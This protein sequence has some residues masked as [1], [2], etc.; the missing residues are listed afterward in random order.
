MS[1]SGELKN[2][3]VGDLS[4]LLSSVGKLGLSQD[5]AKNLFNFLES[6]GSSGK[7][8]KATLTQIKNFLTALNGMN[9]SIL[10]DF[11]TDKL[12]MN[13]LRLLLTKFPTI[14]EQDLLDIL[15]PFMVSE[16]GL[17]ELEEAERQA[18]KDAS[19]NKIKD[20]FEQAGL[21]EYFDLYQTMWE[22]V[23]EK[24]E[25]EANMFRKK[26]NQTFEQK[27]ESYLN[28]QKQE[29]RQFVSNHAGG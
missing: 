20:Y 19:L 2:A 4:K 15:G 12:Q 7:Y 1:I 27:L 25:E 23:K 21:G 3:L 16:K 13:N 18:A 8:N 14:S 6:L 28:E 17:N 10:N 9:N 26:N 24:E 11:L 5:A 22:R 29:T